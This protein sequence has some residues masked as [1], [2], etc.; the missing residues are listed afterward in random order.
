MERHEIAE[1]LKWK[2]TDIFPSDEAWEDAFNSAEKDY[3]NCDFS[4]FK[5]NLHNRETLL[6]CFR[7]IDEISRRLERVYLYAHMR[8]DE[9]VRIS[10]YTSANARVGALFSKV[11]AQFAFVDPELTAL[12]E[13]LLQSFIKSLVMIIKSD[14]T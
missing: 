3:A 13:E 14:F 11:F 10:K 2:I 7:A 1:N 8:H 6:E 4:A 5:G 12:D 9:D